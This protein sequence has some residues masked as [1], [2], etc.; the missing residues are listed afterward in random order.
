MRLGSIIT[1]ITMLTV[2]WGGLL[3]FLNVALKSEK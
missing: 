2:V 1:M 3:F